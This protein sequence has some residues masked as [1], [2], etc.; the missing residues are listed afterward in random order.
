MNQQAADTTI[1]R[2]GRIGWRARSDRGAVGTEMAIVV[3]IVV[4]ISLALGVVMRNSAQAH[5]AC[6][7]ANPGDPVPA[8]C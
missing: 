7:P 4:A 2:R 1:D 8:G 6:I 3:A 5:Q